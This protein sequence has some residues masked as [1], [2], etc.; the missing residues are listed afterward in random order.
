[1]RVPPY[2][3]GIKGPKIGVHNFPRDLTHRRGGTHHGQE[4]K[5]GWG[6]YVA[7]R[8]GVQVANKV[9]GFS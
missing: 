2:T 3:F 7:H 1:M 6:L 8:G 9:F 4:K 5:A